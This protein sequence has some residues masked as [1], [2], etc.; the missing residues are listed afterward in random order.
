MPFSVHDEAIERTCLHTTTR[1]HVII[2]TNT[3]YSNTIKGIGVDY[4]I[5]MG[6]GSI[7]TTVRVIAK[8]TSTCTIL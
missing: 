6:P 3:P 1:I 7:Y 2:T 8:H 5:P 4:L